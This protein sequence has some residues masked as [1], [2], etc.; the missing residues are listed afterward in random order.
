VHCTPFPKGGFMV[1]TWKIIVCLVV[2]FLVTIKVF[3]S[4]SA[5]S[6]LIGFLGVFALT[7]IALNSLISQF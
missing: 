7:T 3:K 5:V 4:G 2:A 1:L 6:V